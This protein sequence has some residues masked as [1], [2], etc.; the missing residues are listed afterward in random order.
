[1]GI[2][3]RVPSWLV[4][5]GAPRLL[6][7]R[8]CIPQRA[9]KCYSC[10]QRSLCY[11][12]IEAYS[13]REGCQVLDTG[14]FGP[15]VGVAC[16]TDTDSGNFVG[17]HLGPVGLPVH[18]QRAFGGLYRHAAGRASPRKVRPIYP[19]ISYTVPPSSS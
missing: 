9:R 19:A 13:R 7:Q 11:R 17:L 12:V 6:Q 5:M 18:S 4:G 15:H 16:T 14:I 8:T 3:G 2:R 10:V 1:M